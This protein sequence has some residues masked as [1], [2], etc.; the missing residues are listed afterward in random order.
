MLEVIIPSWTDKHSEMF[1]NEAFKIDHTLSS[2]GLFTDE[3][4]VDLLNKHP[5]SHLDV[6]ML[7]DHPVYEYKFKSGDA[8]DVDGTTLI[9]AVK[10]GAIWMNLRKAMNLHPEYKTVLDR[11]YG[12][13]SSRT[14]QNSFSA[15]GGILISSPTAKVPYH[16]DA[17]ETILWHVRGHKQMYLYP[18][19]KEFLPDE[20]YENLMFNQSEDYLPYSPDMEDAA[21]CFDLYDDEMLTWPLN[22]PHRVVNKTFCVSVTTEYSTTRSSIKNSVMYANAVL[23]QKFG[24]SPVWRPTAQ[25]ENTLKAGVGKLMRKLGVLDGLQVEDFVSFVVDKNVKGFVREIRPF[26]RDF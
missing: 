22:A 11:M 8:R 4:L 23:R 26:Q 14:G 17:T 10:A 16:F 18:R 1:Q 9:E 13:L 24:M 19:T 3:A 12:E 6:C 5:K 7:G 21:T 25:L 2:T 15:N 20:D